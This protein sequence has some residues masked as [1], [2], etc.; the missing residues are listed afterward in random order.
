MA[1]LDFLPAAGCNEGAFPGA[2]DAHD[3]DIDIPD[4]ISTCHFE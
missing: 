1:D 3:A 2:R 4:I